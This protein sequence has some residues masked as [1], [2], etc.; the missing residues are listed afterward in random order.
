MPAVPGNVGPGCRQVL[1]WSGEDQRATACR[2]GSPLQVGD[3]EQG[4]GHV[5]QRDELAVAPAERSAAGADEVGARA[6]GDGG[7]AVGDVGGADHDPVAPGGVDLPVGARGD[8]PDVAAH[9]GVLVGRGVPADAGD[10]AARGIG[11]GDGRTRGE[12]RE[13]GE[14]D[15]GSRPHGSPPD[16]FVRQHAPARPAWQ[17]SAARGRKPRLSVLRPKRDRL[18]SCMAC[19][20]RSHYATPRFRNSV[21]GA[22]STTISCP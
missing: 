5:Q 4:A 2:V 13:R 17:R 19:E 12:A 21:L 7:G 16:R 8:G 9:A 11:R 20:A 10:Q 6:A 3:G 18:G 15:D 1:P 22:A 14:D